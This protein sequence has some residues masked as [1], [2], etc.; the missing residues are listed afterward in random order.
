IEVLQQSAHQPFVT[1]SIS[2]NGKIDVIRDIVLT[3]TN[4]DANGY[5]YQY[6]IVVEKLMDI[7]KVDLNDTENDQTV[8]IKIK[9]VIDGNSQISFELKPESKV[10]V[11]VFFNTIQYSMMGIFGYI[12]NLIK[13]NLPNDNY[14]KRSRT[15]PPSICKLKTN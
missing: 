4:K 15:T 6:P 13:G 5:L 2:F 8:D 1:R 11:H 12:K 10:S 3:Y 9:E 14:Y 7:D